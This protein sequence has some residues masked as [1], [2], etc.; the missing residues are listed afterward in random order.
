VITR[1]KR[2]LLTLKQ[3]VDKNKYINIRIRKKMINSE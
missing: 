3:E 1:N 2:N